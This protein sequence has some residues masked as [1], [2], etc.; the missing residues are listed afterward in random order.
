MTVR[1]GTFQAA[2]WQ[3][4]LFRSLLE[5]LK[6]IESAGHG[7]ISEAFVHLNEVG[8]SGVITRSSW[9][10]RHQKNPLE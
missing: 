10:H 1:G 5:S 9:S 6:S 2:K 8:C 7:L 3:M 4:L